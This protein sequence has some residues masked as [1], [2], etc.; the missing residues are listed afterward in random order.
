MKRI[1]ESFQEFITSAEINQ[2]PGAWE[3]YGSNPKETLKSVEK[4]A[5]PE[6]ELTGIKAKIDTGADGTSLHVNDI[7]VVKGTLSFWIKS[8]SKRL[9]FSKFDKIKIKNS[10]GKTE[11]RYRINTKIKIRS[12]EFNVLV[13]LANRDKM[14]FP[15]ILG[16]QTIRKGKYMIDLT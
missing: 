12:K 9:E 4:I 1:I 14:K 5:F 13:S 7:K 3:Y 6:L 8:P 2:N 10:F 15:C 16:K 11:Y